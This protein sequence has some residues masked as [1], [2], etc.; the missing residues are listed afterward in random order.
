MVT[1]A[2][3]NDPKKLDKVLNEVAPDPARRPQRDEH[4]DL[5]RGGYVVGFWDQ[6]YHQ[7][8]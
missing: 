4:G 3:I 6:V 1:S 8:G 5:V 2:A 7:T